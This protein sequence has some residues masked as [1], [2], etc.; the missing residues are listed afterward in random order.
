MD[1]FRFAR[2]AQA[3]KIT[4][5]FKQNFK[6]IPMILAGDFNDFP[7]TDPLNKFDADFVD[8]YS[9]KTM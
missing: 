4:E 5:Y 8:L 6:G 1:D 3:A 2:V 7:L 9:L